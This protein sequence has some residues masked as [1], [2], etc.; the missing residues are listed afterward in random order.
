MVE[1]AMILPI[2]LAM[3]MGMMELSRAWE[4]VNVMTSAAREGAR[5]AAITTPD[6]AA[7][8]TAALN[9]LNLAHVENGTVNVSFP[10][11]NQ[12]IIV[13]VQVDYEPITGNF[14]PGLGNF[15]LTRTST[16]RWEG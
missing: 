3:L 16:M 15:T 8:R 11:E 13:T 6:V 10:D 14:V 2:F 7:A 12:N 4:T 9:V 5:V 1:F